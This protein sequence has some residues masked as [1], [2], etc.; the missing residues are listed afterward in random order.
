MFADVGMVVRVVWWM[1]GYLFQGTGRCGVWMVD[2]LLVLL[3]FMP[4]PSLHPLNI[5]GIFL[6]HLYYVACVY[7]CTC[8]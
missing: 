4:V 8:R 3:V 2:D 7:I 6:F 1:G 5:Y